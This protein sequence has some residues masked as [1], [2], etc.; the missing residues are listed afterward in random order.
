MQNKI[1]FGT[2]GIPH[3][4]RERSSQYG[5]IAVKENNLDTMEVEFVRGVRLSLQKAAILKKTAVENNIRLSCHAPYYINLNSDE[6]EKITASRKRI[7]DSAIALNAAGGTNVVFH[8]GFYLK[9]TIEESINNTI[10]N[11]NIVREELDKNQMRHIILRPELTGKPSQIGS[12]TDLM[13]ICN[14]VERTLPC[15]DFSHFLARYN[16]KK[17]FCEL[18]DFLQNNIPEFFKNA[19]CHLSGIEFGAK[20]EKNHLNLDESTVD[21][22]KI[23]DLMIKYKLNGTVICESPSLEK[24]ASIMKRYY[25]EAV[26]KS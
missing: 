1:L 5:I 13:N 3:S 14:N 12:E 26:N 6:K 25:E 8:S 11:L 24:D 22:K 7:I 21:Y 19:H 17:D 10:S 4:A 18:F 23:I 2:A 9:N 16:G 15:I 20:G